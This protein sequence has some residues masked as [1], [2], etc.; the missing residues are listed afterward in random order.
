MIYDD[1]RVLLNVEPCV[2][3]Q[4]CVSKMCQL[5]QAVVLTSMV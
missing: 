3:R 2:K 4:H 1:Y 5:W